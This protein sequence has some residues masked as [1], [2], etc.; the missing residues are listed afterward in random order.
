MLSFSVLV[1][2]QSENKSEKFWAG[3]FMLVDI[4]V[5][6][7]GHGNDRSGPLTQRCFTQSLATRNYRTLGH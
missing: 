5:V 3:L 6:T 4:F 2:A 1:I 7:A